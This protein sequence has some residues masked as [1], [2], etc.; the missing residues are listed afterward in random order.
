MISNFQQLINLL[1]DIKYREWHFGQLV[2]LVQLL[3]T[4]QMA[5]LSPF[6]EDGIV[7]VIYKVNKKRNGN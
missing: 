4:I 2:R 5:R 3:D 7:E 6:C 1:N